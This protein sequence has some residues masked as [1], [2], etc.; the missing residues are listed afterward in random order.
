MADWTYPMDLLPD[1]G[2]WSAGPI[3][4]HMSTV[5]GH[6]VTYPYNQMTKYES[7]HI[8]EHNNT[9][10]NEYVRIAHRTGSEIIMDKDGNITINSGGVRPNP[11]TSR[12]GNRA[13]IT[14]KASADLN[15]IAEQA[16]NIEA[17]SDMTVNVAGDLEYNVG[18]EI[19]YNLS[20]EIIMN[21]HLTVQ[22]ADIEDIG[23]IEGVEI[24]VEDDLDEY[25][26]FDRED[27]SVISYTEPDAV[28]G[29]LV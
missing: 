11:S 3:E 5:E 1:Y 21:S 29:S 7:G 26:L 24:V 16:V 9:P 23:T 19:V 4:Q 28:A 27:G 17:G 10:G 8:I 6:K 18:G 13:D 15:I 20:N 14:I 25:A 12:F 22:S 2:N